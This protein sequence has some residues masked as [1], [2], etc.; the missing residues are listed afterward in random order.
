VS[1][2]VEGYGY[3]V[4][5]NP[6]EVSPYYYCQNIYQFNGGGVIL[7]GIAA[8]SN[9]GVT[10]VLQYGI[11][12][13]YGLPY[14]DGATTPLSTNYGEGRVMVGISSGALALGDL[15]YM[16]TTVGGGT[17]TSIGRWAKADADAVVTSNRIIGVCARQ[18]TNNDDLVEFVIDGLV[19]VDVNKINNK[20]GTITDDLGKP[21]YISPNTGQYSMTAPGTTG[22]VVRIVGHVVA[23]SGGQFYTIMFRPD[24]TW[25]E[26]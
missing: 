18:T 10:N 3:P 13:Y 25:I 16:S 1:T 15:C 6:L 11:T 14:V 4:I 21:V 9:S 7:G 22:Q 20:S 12:N 23:V 26:L 2:V 24:A 19:S 5:Y 17:Y 8:D